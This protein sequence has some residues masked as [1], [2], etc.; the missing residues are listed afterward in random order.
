[1][2]RPIAAFKDYFGL[3]ESY[4]RALAAI[5]G[6]DR[7]HYG[8]RTAALNAITDAMEPG[9]LVL[10]NGVSLSPTGRAECDLAIA[11][12]AKAYPP[13]PAKAKAAPKWKRGSG[14]QSRVLQRLAAGA[15]TNGQLAEHCAEAGGVVSAR[16]ANL[17]DKG[18]AV[19]TDALADS[20]SKRGRPGA[21]YAITEAGRQDL[22]RRGL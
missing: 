10:A 2:S 1:M 6:L 15:C 21:V 8:V 18:F 3:S 7:P 20:P 14:V 17:R 13:K 16:L 19:R 11:E 12:Y 5:Y 9:A 4:A 22:A